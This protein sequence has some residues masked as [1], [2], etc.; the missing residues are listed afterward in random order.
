MRGPRPIRVLLDNERGVEDV[1]LRFDL[2]Y[3]SF[4]DGWHVA[5]RDHSDGQTYNWFLSCIRAL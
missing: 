3:Q 2:Q 1:R 4:S 5:M